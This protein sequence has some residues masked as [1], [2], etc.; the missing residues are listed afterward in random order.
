MRTTKSIL[1]AAKATAP[2]MARISAETLDKALLIIAD[3]LEQDD[4]VTEILAANARDLAAAEGIS[5]VMLDRLRLDRDR[6]HGMAEGIRGVAA[7]PSP[8]E[9]TIDKWTR[10]NGLQ[11]EKISVS[12]GVVAIIY[13]SRPNVTS[14]AAALALKSGNV[15]ILRGGKEAAASSAAIV[16]SIRRGLKVAGLPEDA[17]L[18]IEDTTRQGATEL[19]KANGY[20]DLLIPRGGAG[21]IRACVE[22]ATVPC[23]ETGTGICH[24]YIDRDADLDKALAIVENAKTSRP[25]VCN[26]E[27]VLI[28]HR[29]IAVQLLPSLKARLCDGRSAAGKV[30]VEL[31]CDPRA[32]AIIGGTAAGEKDFDT[33]F[34]DYILAIAVVDSAEEAIEHIRLH[35]THHSDAIVTEN[36]EVAERFA[37]EVDSAAVYVNASTR[38]TDGGEFGFG[39]EMGISTQ[40]LHARG[41]MGLPELTT[42]KYIVRGDG[43]IR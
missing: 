8:L 7:L 37:K 33:E 29:D 3:I 40:K 4:S 27:E 28:V 43:Q 34:L 5:P 24:I 11:I 10:P 16:A 14:D 30:P 35:S 9:K 2:A 25:S 39:C 12:I 38:F 42:Y 26:A 1:E 36:T 21:L 23:I 31:R 6:I 18:R 20:V 22:N 19:M 41:P 15:C 32:H 17:V 13:E